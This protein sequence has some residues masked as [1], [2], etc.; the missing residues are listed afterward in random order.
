MEAV[1]T[2]ATFERKDTSNTKIF[3]DVS[4]HLLTSIM[5]VHTFI[6][7]SYIYWEG[8]PAENLYFVKKGHIQLTKMSDEGSDLELYQYT[9]DDLFGDLS[10]YSSD[11]YELSASAV[12]DAELGVIPQKELEV[13][14]SQNGDFAIEFIRWM[15]FMHRRTQLHLR[16][17][18]FYGKQGALAS[19]LIRMANTF[20]KEDEDHSIRIGVKFT[21]ANI[22]GMIGATRETVNRMISKMKK[23][24]I[25][26]MKKGHII[27]HQL[28]YLKEICHCEGCSSN[29]CRL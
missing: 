8:D 2:N 17:L 19:T 22:A 4:F 26:D 28:D 29:L 12:T 10:N 6:K 27:I 14:L 11:R 18:L 5:D 23:D 25:L 13:L 3:S 9:K 20:G 15:G 21:N 1:T 7:D 24:N 16:D